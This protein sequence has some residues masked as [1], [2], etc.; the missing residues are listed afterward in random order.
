MDDFFHKTGWCRFPRDPELS[1][2]IAS[3]LP[4]ARA[5][6]TAPDNAKWLRCGGTWFAGVNVLPN[7]E[8]GA[9]ATGPPLG[10]EAAEFIRNALGH[11]GI[12][13][14]RA[15]VSVCYPGYPQKTEA[16]SDRA[17]RYRRDHAAAHVDG[18]LPVGEERR[19][20]LREHHAFLLGLPMVEASA[21]ASPFVVWEGS[22]EIL[23]KALCDAFGDTPPER[24]RDTDVTEIYHAARRRIF[25]D[26]RC[27]EIAARPGEAYVVHRLALHGMA[28]WSPDATRGPDGRMIVYFRPALLT[29]QQ[30][31]ERP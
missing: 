30:W 3:A 2:W 17:F 5:A 22:H 27:V 26:C 25:E 12:A 6:V 1:A 13:W 16:E 23:R 24:W 19:R 11:R 31:L 8:R 21:D 4:A 10:G 7:D 9:V 15:Q 18:L 14:E 29:A 20:H 28:R